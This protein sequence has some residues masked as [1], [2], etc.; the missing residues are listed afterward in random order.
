MIP[1]TGSLVVLDFARFMPLP[2]EYDAPCSIGQ[3]NLQ[4]VAYVENQRYMELG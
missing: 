3:Y 2:S 1:L 4:V